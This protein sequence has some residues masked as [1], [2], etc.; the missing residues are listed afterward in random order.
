VL[1]NENYTDLSQ[2]HILPFYEI[3]DGPEARCLLVTSALDD[4]Y[5]WLNEDG[6]CREDFGTVHAG[7]SFVI[8]VNL[9]ESGGYLLEMEC[10]TGAYCFELNQNVMEFYQNWNYLTI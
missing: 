5:F 1:Y 7:D 2:F 3:D 6:Y 4:T 10:S 9:P 8:R